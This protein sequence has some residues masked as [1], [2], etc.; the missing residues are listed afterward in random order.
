[1]YNTCFWALVLQGGRTVQEANKEL[2]VS[3]SP[4]LTCLPLPNS[5]GGG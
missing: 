1:M 3:L 4:A 2:S 5:T